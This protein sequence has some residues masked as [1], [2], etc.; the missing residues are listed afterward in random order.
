MSGIASDTMTLWHRVAADVDHV[1]WER[2]VLSGVRVEELRGGR[3]SHPGPTPSHGLSAYLF[4]DVEVSPHDRVA[5][6]VHDSEAPAEG[7]CE[8]T[9]VRRY[10]LGAR[11]HHM[12]VEAR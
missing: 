7:S 9:D 5:E 6:G 1:S 10:S 2:S 11:L 12:E 8:V 3:G 4:E